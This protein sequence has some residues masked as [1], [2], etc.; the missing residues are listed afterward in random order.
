MY[1]L[2]HHFWREARTCSFHEL[3]E[4]TVTVKRHLKGVWGQFFQTQVGVVVK[5]VILN[6]EAIAMKVR[7]G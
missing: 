3:V 7:N 4:K 6:G 1:H 2:S 5:L